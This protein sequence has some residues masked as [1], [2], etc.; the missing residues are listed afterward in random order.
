[1]LEQPMAYETK[2]PGTKVAARLEHGKL[3][4]EELP[5]GVVADASFSRRHSGV[6]EAASPERRNELLES[7]HQDHIINN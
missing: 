6:R 5:S 7:Q 3:R 1:M 4:S 2:R